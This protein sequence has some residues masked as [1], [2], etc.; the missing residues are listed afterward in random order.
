MLQ[1]LDGS[2]KQNYEE[3]IAFIEFVNKSGFDEAME[4]NSSVCLG[5]AI[6][7]RMASGLSQV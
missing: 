4:L 6:R 5:G 2:N 3:C 1:N 7:V